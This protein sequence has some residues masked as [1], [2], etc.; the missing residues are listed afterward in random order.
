MVNRALRLME[1]DLIIELGFFIRD[2]HNYIVTLHAEQYGGHHHPD[3]FIVYRG[4]GLSQTDF[5]KL[6]YY[7]E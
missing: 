5:D 3:S 2:L 7:I 6:N 1:V 4:Q